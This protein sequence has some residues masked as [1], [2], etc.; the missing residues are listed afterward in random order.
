MI[1][2]FR[3]QLRQRGR[4]STREAA[5]AFIASR[6]RGLSWLEALR[7]LDEAPEPADDAGED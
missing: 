4:V 2:H 3:R 1:A 6:C 7:E 5:L